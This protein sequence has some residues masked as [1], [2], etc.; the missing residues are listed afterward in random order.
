MYSHI[1]P[2]LHELNNSCNGIHSS[3]LASDDGL[4][5]ATTMAQDLN[6]DCI[7]NLSAGTFLLSKHMSNECT[8]GELTLVLIKCK[9]HC[10]IM[11]QASS[12][13]ILTVITHPDADLDVIFHHIRQFA[14]KISYLLT[15]AAEA[16]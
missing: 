10:V 9:A 2:H 5:M 8:I 3:A 12:E 1:I 13:S 7:A 11:M 6:E 4:I 15:G 14:E 16:A